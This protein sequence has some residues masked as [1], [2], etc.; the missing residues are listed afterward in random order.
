MM[1]KLYSRKLL[2]SRLTGS[3]CIRPPTWKGRRKQVDVVEVRCSVGGVVVVVIRC[4]YCVEVISS[5]Y[6]ALVSLYDCMRKF[7]CLH[8]SL[9]QL[10]LKNLEPRK[11]SVEGQ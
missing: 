1:R 9:L 11:V 7:G 6:H 5:S 3:H 4:Y 10:L 8:V 2:C